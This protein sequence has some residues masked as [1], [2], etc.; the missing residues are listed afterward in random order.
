MNKVIK[1]A[2][3]YGMWIIDLGLAFWFAYMS[4]TVL[5]GLFA[6]F[7]KQGEWEYAKAVNFTDRVSTVVLG[8]GWLA[9]SIVVEDYYRKGASEGN[10]LKRIT[11]VTGPVLLGLFVVDLIL[12][13]LQG[14][15]SDNW[16]RWLILAGELGIGIA[17][18]VSGKKKQPYK[19]K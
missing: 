15:S 4:R 13:W 16:L 17:L 11:R 1:Y 7:S 18:F 19:P 2:I 10:L 12:F 8:L 3:A 14:I 6:L 5:L 9:F